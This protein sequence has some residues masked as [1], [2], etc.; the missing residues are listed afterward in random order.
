[1]D[2]SQ[3]QRAVGERGISTYSEERLAAVLETL[4]RFWKVIVVAD[5]AILL[6][7]G[8]VEQIGGSPPTI[9]FGVGSGA[10]ICVDWSLIPTD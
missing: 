1:M 8:R 4:G 5:T 6:N 10:R 2:F 9:P 7:L 3:F